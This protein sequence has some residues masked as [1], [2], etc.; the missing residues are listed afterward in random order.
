MQTAKQ[1][2]ESMIRTLPDDADFED[3]QYRLY[4]L[5]KIHAGLASL[6]AEGGIPHDAVRKRMAPWLGD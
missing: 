3:I 6:D 1:A 2:T 4:V 5:G